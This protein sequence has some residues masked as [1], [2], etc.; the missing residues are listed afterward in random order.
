ML[1]AVVILLA[2]EL[3]VPKVFSSLELHMAYRSNALMSGILQVVS[4]QIIIPQV[5]K[6]FEKL[7]ANLHLRQQNLVP[8]VG[9][10]NQ[11]T[12]PEELHQI[13]SLLRLI[14][15]TMLRRM[16]GSSIVALIRS[17]LQ[18]VVKSYD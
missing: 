18:L 1:P 2:H 12:H 7:G 15:I 13:Y 8:K 5:G 6:V 3:L 14:N 11:H 10:I 9:K 16:L 17:P 4:M